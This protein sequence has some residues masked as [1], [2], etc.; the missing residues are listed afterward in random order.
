MGKITITPMMTHNWIT[1]ATTQAKKKVIKAIVA[2]TNHS[3]SSWVNKKLIKVKTLKPIDLKESFIKDK[4]P[5]P[6]T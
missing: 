5:F 1:V 2:E 6:V 3:H 4:N